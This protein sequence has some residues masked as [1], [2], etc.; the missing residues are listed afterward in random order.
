[1]KGALKWVLI[2]GGGY[3]VASRTNLLCMV[4]V[5]ASCGT[6]AGAPPT[7]GPQPGAT[8]GVVTSPVA[9]APPPTPAPTGGGYV[10]L[11]A[12]LGRL[13]AALAQNNTPQSQGNYV[14]TPWGFNYWL[15]QVSGI[16]IGPVIGQLF[17]GCGTGAACDTANITL[18]QFWSAVAPYLQ[19]SKGLSGFGLARAAAALRGTGCNGYA[20]RYSCFPVSRPYALAMARQT[21]GSHS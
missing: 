20:G 5:G 11:A 15:N 13:Q 14:A 8:P 7:G 18:P 16:D 1:M 10:S 4:G 17:P 3:L 6:A 21:S 12:I 19:S 2:L 9:A